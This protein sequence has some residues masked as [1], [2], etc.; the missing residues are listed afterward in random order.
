MDRR[1]KSAIV[2]LLILLLPSVALLAQDALFSG[3]FTERYQYRYRLNPA[4]QNNEGFLAPPVLGGLYADVRSNADLSTFL[5]LKSNG[6]F[7]SFLSPSVNRE[8]F[9]SG[10]NGAARL[11]HSSDVTILAFGIKKDR[12]YHTFEITTNTASSGYIPEEI[13]NFLK[14]PCGDLSSGLHGTITGTAITAYGYSHKV[15]DRFSIGARTKFILGLSDYSIH[16]YDISF[17]PKDNNLWKTETDGEASAA[18]LM[19]L[20]KSD[21]KLSVNIL[22]FNKYEPSYGGALDLGFVYRIS[23][24]LTVSGS[25]TD[26]GLINWKN[27][28]TSSSSGSGFYEKNNDFDETS[29]AKEQISDIIDALEQG[30]DFGAVSQHSSRSSMLSPTV[31]LGCQF[32]IPDINSLSFGLLDS[33]RT[34]R[35]CSWNEI[36]LSTNFSPATWFSMSANVAESPF[37]ISTGAL[38]YFHGKEL[39]LF[40]GTDDFMNFP[41]IRKEGIPIRRLSGNISIGIIYSGK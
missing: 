34:D 33:Y 10:I 5:Y 13:L 38:F 41:T 19:Q 12:T 35:Q 28:T 20:T 24:W 39:N 27:V 4:I 11:S 15:N 40:M 30:I 14:E 9:L 17:Y 23:D 29:N 2:S 16:V 1:I 22:G 7:T 36:R 25:M 8:E 32:S 18:G 26:L 6:E 21:N 31:H 3:Y 37:G